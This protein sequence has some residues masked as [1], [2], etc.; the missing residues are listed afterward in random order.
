MTM[1]TLVLI[2]MLGLGT[3]ATAYTPP[4]EA[5]G[6]IEIDVGRAPPPP[7]FEH[8]VVRHGYVWAPG[9]W[10]WEGRRHVWAAGYWVRERP[11]Y[12]WIGPRWQHHHHGWRFHGGYWMRR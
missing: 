9:Y 8:V 4:A 11:A 1:R 5:R 12:V 3:A 7:R 6:F 10:R 2:A